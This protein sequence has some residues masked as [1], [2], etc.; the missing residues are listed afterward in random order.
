MRFEA[1]IAKYLD[2]FQ[3]AYDNAKRSGVGSVELAT[4]PVV[5]NFV[6]ALAKHVQPEAFVHHDS[7]VRGTVYRP[8]W[9]IEDES[10]F[11]VYV[12]GDH[13]NLNPTAPFELSTGERK[14]IEGYLKLGRPVFVFDGIEFLF[15][16]KTLGSCLRLSLIDKVLLSKNKW[17]SCAISG[18]I[19]AK[20]KSILDAPGFRQWT[21]QEL[22]CQLAYRAAALS[23]LVREL[24]DAPPGSG[25]D[26]DEEHL[27][28]ALVKLW[29]VVKDHHDSALN[30]TESCATFVAQVL[31]FGLFFAHTQAAASAKTPEGRRKEIHAFWELRS[32][33]D[34]ASHLR[35][36]QTIIDALATS[37]GRLNV[38]SEWYRETAMLLAH[39]EY[40]GCRCE[41]SDYHVL[42][43]KFFASYDNDMKF[44]HGAFYTPES[45][46]DWMVRSTDGLISHHFGG[47]RL[48]Q[49]AE[50]I[51]DPCCGTGSFLEAVIRN[52]PAGACRVPGLVGFEIL[53]APYALAHYRLNRAIHGTPFEHSVQILL[54]DTLAD[55]AIPTIRTRNGFTEEWNAARALMRPPL[56]VVI[57]NPPS[58]IHSNST[59]SRTVI[60][61]MMNSFRPPL[62]SRTGR[63]NV[64]K[65]LS[66]EAFRFLRWCCQRVIETN[67]GV[68]SLVLPGS[69]ADGVS[70]RHARR[71]LLENFDHLYLLQL[72]ADAR[73]GEPTDSIFRVKQ[74]RL[75][76][77]AI[78]VRPGT[79]ASARS[80]TTP[81]ASSVYARDVTALNLAAKHAFLKDV[82]P[83]QDIFAHLNVAAPDYRFSQSGTTSDALWDSCWPLLQSKQSEGVFCAKCSGVK[84][85]PS[86][87]L[88]HSSKEILLRRSAEIG[89]QN[90]AGFV[91]P[92]GALLQKWWEGQSKPPNKSKLSAEVRRAFAAKHLSHSVVR[93]SFRPFLEGSVIYDSS[94]FAALNACP[95]GGTR[96]RPELHAAFGSGGVGFALAPA[97]KD[98]GTSLTRLSSFVWHLPD[99][100]L[101]SRGNAM[102]Y[103]D[104]LPEVRRGTTST[105]APNQNVS[106]SFSVWFS[107]LGGP[108]AAVFY[109]YGVV[110]STKYLTRFR[111]L[112]FGPANPDAPPRIPLVKNADLRA[113]LVSL[114]KRIAECEQ[115]EMTLP[116]LPSIVTCWTGEPREFELDRCVVDVAR[117][118]VELTE[119]GS[120]ILSFSGIPSSVLALRI[121]GHDVIAK[122]LRE[123][124]FSYLRRKFRLSDGALLRSLIS[125]IA[126][127]QELIKQVD[128][129]L[130]I[131]L[132]SRELIVP[133][134][135]TSTSTP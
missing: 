13:K 83:T 12:F 84:L 129:A 106:N 53:P 10:N 19:E 37:L 67:S 110:S 105:P 135:I 94:V 116:E 101:V 68:V 18:L 2:D 125:R 70:F 109:S 73:T 79:R 115:S 112:L 93:Y 130:A 81:I 126:L 80:N 60:D 9:R 51:I 102:I 134:T 77:F 24:L 117:G 107:K 1:I 14:Q 131:A 114:G 54:T 97:P 88:F 31:T 52:T 65:A 99:N 7:T 95:G 82:Q 22:I 87:L 128:A 49:I 28:D 56:R 29:S 48:M 41:P 50:K 39:A 111:P 42:F 133:A 98:L 11:G 91:T 64:Q 23:G 71:W 86:A 108:S 8:D 122:W 96:S 74:G 17:S 123:Y 66:N 124:R 61:S 58:T 47:Q 4:R 20:F 36:F 85:A 3:D 40:L 113:Q 104:L 25:V 34:R 26:A 75:V 132:D 38:L 30:T 46:A 127:Q 89:A 6:V 43:E 16:E 76:L 55:H 90:P 45:L 5:H 69:F 72:D 21:E 63:Q 59:A 33:V 103:C 32:A 121:A 78:R 27:I 35:P 92:T 57:G 15:F 118:L 120:T 44:D 100:D 62:G 119:A